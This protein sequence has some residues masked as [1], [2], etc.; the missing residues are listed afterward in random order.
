MKKAHLLVGFFVSYSWRQ[1]RPES[2]PGVYST[3]FFEAKMSF[4]HLEQ[5]YSRMAL[6]KVRIHQLLLTRAT[7]ANLH[8][9]AE[10][11]ILIEALHF[12][13]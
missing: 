12:K 10:S 5:W 6:K 7:S 8:S 2:R 4:L 11:M 1:T 9:H 13:S 3:R